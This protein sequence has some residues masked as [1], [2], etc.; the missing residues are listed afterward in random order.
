MNKVTPSDR[1][2]E[3]SLKA[4]RDH[5]DVKQFEAFGTHL[6]DWVCRMRVVDAAGTVYT[7][8]S[9]GAEVGDDEINRHINFQADKAEMTVPV[10]APA[11]A[12]GADF[13]DGRWKLSSRICHCPEEKPYARSARSHDHDRDC[14]RSIGRKRVGRVLG[15][16]RSRARRSIWPIPRS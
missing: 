13:A 4:L 9:G 5:G 3:I 14:R 1:G 2:F 6:E 12:A 15:A 16:K 11:S 8:D 10:K 7:S